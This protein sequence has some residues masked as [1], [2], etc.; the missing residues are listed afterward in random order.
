[1]KQTIKSEL[2]L[3]ES[4]TSVVYIYA[5]DSRYYLEQLYNGIYQI[6]ENQYN[7]IEKY[8]K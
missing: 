4:G 8:L 7:N 3:K 2:N 5:N 1:M 6:R